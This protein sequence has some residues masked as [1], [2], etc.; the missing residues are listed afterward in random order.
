ME[1]YKVDLNAKALEDCN[2]SLS[3]ALAFKGGLRR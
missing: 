2:V 3:K 1:N